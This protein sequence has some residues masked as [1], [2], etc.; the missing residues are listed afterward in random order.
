M[1]RNSPHHTTLIDF[2]A[3]PLFGN[4]ENKCVSLFGIDNA[5]LLQP[6]CQFILVAPGGVQN[7]P[8]A[9]KKLLSKY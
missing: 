7:R 6:L 5:R 4:F 9:V 1:G 8:S 2:G 3:P